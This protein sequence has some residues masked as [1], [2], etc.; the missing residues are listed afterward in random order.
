MSHIPTIAMND[1]TEVILNF[2]IECSF[3]TVKIGITIE[4]NKVINIDE[5]ISPADPGMNS[6]PRPTEPGENL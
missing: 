5:I 3:I 1:R 2:P 4:S 6:V